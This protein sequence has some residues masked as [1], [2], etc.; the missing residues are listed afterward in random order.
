[1]RLS[2]RFLMS[3]ATGGML[4]A[5]PAP[6]LVVHAE[7]P[8]P[9]AQPSPAPPAAP[10][11]NKP[12]APAPAKAEESKSEGKPAPTEAK[13]EPPK[14]ETPKAQTPAPVPAPAQ[15]TPAQ[16]PKPKTE[17]TPPAAVQAQPKSELPIPTVEE[18]PVS[19][20]EE[21]QFVEMVNE[22]RAKRGLSRLKIDPLLI[23]VARLHSAEMRDKAYF[24]H[25]SPT[26]SIKTPLDRYLKACTFRPTYACVGENLFWATVV[27]VKR[28]HQAFMN[29]PTHRENVLFPRYEKIGVG[30]V[31]RGGEF[32]VTQMYL[33]NT[34]PVSVAKN[35]TK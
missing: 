35:R 17:A 24:A 12:A 31:K 32:W 6:Y 29:S 14:P 10:A 11:E 18:E 22:E 23:K 21:L 8:A 33:T 3:L 9:P 26:Q 16:E 27:D 4:L 25:E 1:M 28:G 2:P 20:Q 13:P 19:T 34:D 30:I 7:T 15:P 5:F